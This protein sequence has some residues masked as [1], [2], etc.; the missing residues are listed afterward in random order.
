MSKSPS[1]SLFLKTFLETN[2]RLYAEDPGVMKMLDGVTEDNIVFSKLKT[3]TC[4]EGLTIVECDLKSNGKVVGIK[5]SWTPGDYSSDLAFVITDQPISTEDL[6]LIN[7]VGLFE[8]VDN[9]SNHS[10]L[11]L[12]APLKETQEQT[13]FCAA[14]LIDGFCKYDLVDDDI[15]IEEDIIVVSDPTV[16]GRIGLRVVTMEVKE[17]PPAELG[18]L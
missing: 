5:Q 4:E 13:D 7:S 6:L 11:V 10:G 8:V 18:E 12:I 9:V 17:I 15:S 3:K 2:R 16:M 14:R 1:S